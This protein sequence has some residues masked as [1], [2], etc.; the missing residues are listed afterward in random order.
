[1]SDTPVMP[2]DHV[3]VV[4]P[5]S[6]VLEDAA[7]GYTLKKNEPRFIHRSLLKKALEL[8]CT[9]VNEEVTLAEV[10]TAP[11]AEVTYLSVDDAFTYIVQKNERDMF[12]ATGVPTPATMKE[13]TG[14]K[15]QL[16]ELHGMWQEYKKRQLAVDED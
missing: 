12:T 14:E 8:G 5:R 2:K 6:F 16:K 10:I 13:L 3:E 15:Y 7:R 1:M 11:K 4:S 9:T